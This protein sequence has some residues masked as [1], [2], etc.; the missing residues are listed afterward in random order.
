MHTAW[1]DV[2]AMRLRKHE[3]RTLEP[4][5]T[6]SVYWTRLGSFYASDSWQRLRL[7]VLKK[8]GHKCERCHFTPADGAIMHVDHIKPRSKYP[9]LEL[10]ESNCQ[11]LCEDCNLA[12]SNYSDRRGLRK[13]RPQRGHETALRRPLPP[14]VRS[15]RFHPGA[16]DPSDAYP[17]ALV[18]I[19]LID[20]S[21]AP[22][23]ATNAQAKVPVKRNADAGETAPER[24]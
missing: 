17:P 23:A 10:V 15:K 8:R 3:Q 1:D 19:R 2:A 12:K 14:A 20:D 22:A 9:E 13:R 18:P 5:H 16:D 24:G 7:K 4:T 21:V 11:V 6:E